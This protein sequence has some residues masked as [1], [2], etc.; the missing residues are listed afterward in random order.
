MIKLYNRHGELIT[1]LT[2]GKMSL[3]NRIV[4]LSSASPEIF[5]AIV[6]VQ[7][8]KRLYTMS[9]IYGKLS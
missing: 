2:K 3:R 4:S 6:V 7:Y 9:D 8:G 5:H 1:T